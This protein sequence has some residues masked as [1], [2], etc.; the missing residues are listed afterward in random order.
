M[1]KKQ[2]WYNN[3]LVEHTLLKPIKDLQADQLIIISGYASHNMA[4]WHIKKISERKLAPIKIDLT[5]GMPQA[6]GVPKNIH[7]GLQ[8]LTKLHDKKLSSFSCKYIYQGAPVHSKIYIWLKEQ[9]PVIAFAGSANYSQ[10]AFSKNRREYMVQCDHNEAYSYYQSLEN[11]SIFCNHGEIEEYI[12]IHRNKELDKLAIK[13]E[14]RK[15]AIK[16]PCVTL[17]LLQKNGKVGHGSGINWGHRKNGIKREPNQTYIPLPSK[18]AKSNFFPLNKQHFSV[19]TDDR[20]QLI[21]RVQQQN[22]KAIT[23]P[24][25]NSQLG[26]YIRNRMG[27]PNGKFVTLEDFANYGRSDVTFYKIDDDQFYMDFSV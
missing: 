20:K 8:N 16:V 17:S 27:L 5:F 26:E 6:D 14:D 11:D 22:D 7:E 12:T 19:I 23:T 2:T 18:I 21:L 15:K 3:K 1:N 13:L 25:N 24:L 9:K 10:N 4:S